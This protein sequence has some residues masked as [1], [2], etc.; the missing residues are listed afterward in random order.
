M[1][2]GDVLRAAGWLPALDPAQELLLSALADPDG[3]RRDFVSAV[4]A[5]PG[6]ALLAATWRRAFTGPPGH[7]EEERGTDEH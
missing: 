2:P 1:D 4:R 7:D 6:G 5:D 3:S